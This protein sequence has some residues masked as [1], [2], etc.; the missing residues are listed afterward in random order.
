MPGLAGTRFRVDFLGEGS[1]VVE[2]VTEQMA[3]AS[4]AW[5]GDE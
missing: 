2:L 5:P 1:C 3:V 4:L